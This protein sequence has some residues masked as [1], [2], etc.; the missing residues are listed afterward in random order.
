M[1]KPGDLVIMVDGEGYPQFIW[2]TTEVTIK[3]YLRWTRRSPGMRGRGTARESSGS[4]ATAAISL[5]KRRVKGSR[6]TTRT[7]PCSNASRWSGRSMSRR[8]QR[9]DFSVDLMRAN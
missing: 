9:A 5:G 8:D 2:R 6:W 3:P 7:S 4:M 1:P